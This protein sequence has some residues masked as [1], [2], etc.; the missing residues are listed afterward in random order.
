VSINY[1][2]L[3][4]FIAETELAPWLETLPQ[5]TEHA[6]F[7]SNNGHIPKWT[8]ALEELP[9]SSPSA[10]DLSLPAITIGTAQDISPDEQHSLKETLMTFHPWRK[11]PFS[12]FGRHID[13][14][15]QSNLKWDRLAPH[16]SNLANRLVLDIGSGNGYYGWR[17]AAAGA[18]V[19]GIDP[20]LLYVMQF[21]A[22]RQY[23]DPAIINYVL[24][25]GLE[26]APETLPVFDT[27]LS[28]G[29]LYHRRSPI[30]HLLEM[31][32]YLRPGGEFV[33]ETIVVDGPEGHSLLP[34][35]RY[36]KMRNVWFIPSAPTLENWLKRCGY[37]NVRIVDV[38][39]TTIDEQRSTPWM[40][41][42]SLKDYLDPQDPARTIEGY[43]APKRAIAIASKAS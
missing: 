23:I 7:K 13:T 12:F 14:E 34:K 5:R 18:R 37:A 43:P 16:L 19:I 27:V 25:F 6:I 30:D 15:W 21:H 2:P 33:L 40:T 29:V 41:F 8:R 4:D 39:P 38:A 11:G 24:P 17:M 3:Y 10:I 26:D 31:G 1:Q 28:M 22:A 9:A 35:G 20:F 36:A 32:R 42:E